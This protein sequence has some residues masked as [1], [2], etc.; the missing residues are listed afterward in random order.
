MAFLHFQPALP[1]DTQTNRISADRL[2]YI[3]KSLASV[4]IALSGDPVSRLC[5]RTSCADHH[6]SLHRMTS[7]GSV[8]PLRRIITLCVSHQTSP[9]P[10][11]LDVQRQA[12]AQFWCC[13]GHM[14]VT[15]NFEQCRI[16][17]TVVR[18]ELLVNNGPVI[19]SAA[20]PS[21]LVPI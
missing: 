4:L 3:G 6:I 2:S 20:H 11:C 10:P 16:W 7:K 13:F 19:P 17:Y 12:P 1:L 18:A 14:L 15:Q 21:T 8:A 9:R 5:A